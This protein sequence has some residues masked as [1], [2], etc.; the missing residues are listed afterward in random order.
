MLISRKRYNEL[1]LAIDKASC[2]SCI[3]CEVRGADIC[4]KLIEE[5]SIDD[6]IAIDLIC[7]DVD[8]HSI[9]KKMTEEEHYAWRHNNLEVE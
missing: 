3:N 1:G 7:P 4:C 6:A 9:I 5:M 2:K 8:I